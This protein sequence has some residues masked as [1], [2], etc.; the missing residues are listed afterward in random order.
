MT[1]RDG[2][3]APAG[4]LPL[5]VVAAVLGV[6]V[7]TAAQSAAAPTRGGL[8]SRSYRYVLGARI[9]PLF[10]WIG[11]ENVGEARLAW[12]TGPA[13]KRG[14]ELLIGSDPM[15][16]PRS[17]NR[18]GYITE[19]DEE[20]GV[21]VFGFMTEA[22]EQSLE[23]ATASTGKLPTGSRVFKV[24]HAL[25]AGGRAT[26]DVQGVALSDR[27]TLHDVDAVIAQVP[28]ARTSAPVPIPPGTQPGFLFAMASL[29]HENVPGATTALP[30]ASGRRSY[31]YANK[32]YDVCTRS[33]RVLSRT[34]IRGQEYRD[35]IE[36]VFEARSRVDGRGGVF[37]VV[38]G[39]SGPLKEIPVRIVYRPNWWF[40][41]EV[42]LSDPV[43]RDCGG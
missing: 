22:D 6:G 8:S 29:L 2:S 20:A 33:S 11:K 27:W 10:F 3:R 28:S 31:V 30:A 25:V 24:I 17:I 1:T 5:L 34:T 35:V 19:V 39:A 18:W 40:E 37:K 41:A 26:A 9:R 12:L 21:R 7:S 43:S 32:L 23:Q 13:G 15:R 14:Y 38:Y 36:S 42:V 4:A 16:A